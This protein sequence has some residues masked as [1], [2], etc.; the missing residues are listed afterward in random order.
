MVEQPPP[1]SNNIFSHIP[2]NYI[3]EHRDCLPHGSQVG[4]ILHSQSVWGGGIL[5]FSVFQRRRFTTV[6]Y[7]LYFPHF[8]LPNPLS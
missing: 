1:S 8:L 2:V 4:D 7:S 3:W 6:L 5:A